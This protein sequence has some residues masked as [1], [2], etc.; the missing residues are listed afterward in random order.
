MGILSPK[1]ETLCPGAISTIVQ[2]F[3]LIGVTVAEISVTGQIHT[4]IHTK[5]P[6]LISDKVAFVDKNGAKLYHASRIS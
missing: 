3:T 5:T 1:E 4:K 2:N 6:D